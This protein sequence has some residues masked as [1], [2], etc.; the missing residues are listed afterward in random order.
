MSKVISA[1]FGCGKTTATLKLK[2]KKRIL[3]LDASLFY[4]NNFPKNYIDCLKKNIDKYDIIFVCSHEII[5][6]EM[7]KNNIEYILYYP[8]ISRKNEIIELYKQRGNNER[9]LKF[10]NNNFVNFI[11]SIENDKYSK[12][13]I[14]LKN[15]CDFILNDNFFKKILA[16]E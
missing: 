12:L 10:I 15:E 1:F 14:K 6:N 9:F 2:D 7:K 16:Y 8:D 5:R 4:N 13:K 11:E 3:D